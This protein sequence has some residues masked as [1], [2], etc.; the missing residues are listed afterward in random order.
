MDNKAH[1]EDECLANPYLNPIMLQMC[2][3]YEMEKGEL[4]RMT[5]H[6]YKQSFVYVILRLFQT[7]E[8]NQ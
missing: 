2:L 8:Q 4:Y 1:D 3:K 5:N 6:E 7:L